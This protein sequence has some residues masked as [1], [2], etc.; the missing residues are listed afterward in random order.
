MK[1]VHGPVHGTIELDDFA[2]ELV[3]T[4][5]FQ[6]LR[7]ITQLGFVFLAYPTARHT[8]F[9]HSLGTFHLARK[10]VDHNPDVERG[11]IYAALLHDLGQY[12]FSH[13]LEAIY[14]RHEENTAWFIKNGEVRDIIEESYSIGEFLRFLKHPVVSGDIDADRMDYLIRDAYY[15]GVAYGLVDLDRLIRN[16]HWD[17][18]RLVVLEKG[19]MAAQNLLLARSMMYPTVYL[20]HV[21][22]IAGAMLVEAVK[23]EGIPLDE[24]RLMDEID[25]VARLRTSDKPEVRGLIRAIDSRKLYKRVIW[26]SEPLERDLLEE[27]RR[28]LE[29]EFGHLAL[30]DYPP[31]PKFEEKNAF[32][33][34]EGKLRRLSDVSPLV[35][36][37]FE[38][39]DTYWRWGVYA[40][41]SEVERVR[42]LV[43][44]LL[45]F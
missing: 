5:E 32:V 10:L 19:I 22:R 44:R 41:N 9:E 13:T 1:L 12:P 24:I 29:A 36:S 21:S 14:P 39:K 15:T 3:D 31:K 8:R 16:L 18:E 43:S 20:H 35:R 26:S 34:V 28:E 45:V 7:R 40:E 37:L 25:L 38:L 4:P 6:R 23:L 42:R 33:L 17:G 27:L 30:L 11:V 2:V